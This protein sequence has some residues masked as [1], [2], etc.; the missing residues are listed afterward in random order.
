MLSPHFRVTGFNVMGKVL[1][2]LNGPGLG[3]AK[4]RIGELD[5][6][7]TAPDGTYTISNIKAG[8]YVFQIT[9]PDYEFSDHTF[10]VST[11]NTQLPNIIASA[12]KVCGKIVSKT[13]YLVQIT[14]GQTSNF[15]K[16]IHSNAEGDWCTHLPKGSYKV[17]VLI[18]DE[19]RL[20]GVQ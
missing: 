4:I 6:I 20:N 16:Q 19:E 10:R 5:T 14:G 18:S 7:L 1:T 8:T 2:S 9:S 13:S 12:Y 15:V 3:N 11:A 17:E